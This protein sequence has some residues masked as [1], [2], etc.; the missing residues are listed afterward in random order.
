MNLLKQKNPKL[1]LK[2]LH[3]KPP[4]Q[5]QKQ[6]RAGAAKAKKS[7]KRL[8]VKGKRSI[9]LLSFTL[10]LQSF[11]LEK[12]NDRRPDSQGY[13]DPNPEIALFTPR[14]CSFIPISSFSKI[15]FKIFIYSTC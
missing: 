7:K 5:K 14:I 15:H 3:L 2:K 6:R 4:R 1:W 8:K 12:I 11:Y 10:T 9:C 13:H